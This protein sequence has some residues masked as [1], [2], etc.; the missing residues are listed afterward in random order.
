MQAARQDRNI[1]LVARLQELG[2]EITLEEVQARGRALTARPHFAQVMLEKGY[3]S[4]IQRAF[5]DYLDESAKGYVYRREPPFSEG[6]QRIRDAGGVASLAHPV[7]VPWRRVG[8][9]A[10]TS[11]FG[12]SARRR[13]G[14]LRTGFLT[15]ASRMFFS[16]QPG[17]LWTMSSA[18]N[19]LLGRPIRNLK[20]RFLR[21]N[22]PIGRA[23]NC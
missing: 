11:G 9:H 2:L 8:A 14:S 10:G 6:V 17:L 3:V 18:K 13:L 19:I 23:A 12:V 16:G 5:D 15:W 22:D 21:S 1:R 4:T 7:R 20:L